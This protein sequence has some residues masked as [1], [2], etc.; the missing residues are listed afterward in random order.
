MSNFF[1]KIN[2]WSLASLNILWILVLLLFATLGSPDP[3][4]VGVLNNLIFGFFIISLIEIFFIHKF[5]FHKKLIHTYG[6]FLILIVM[7]I[8]LVLVMPPEKDL[9][10]LGIYVVITPLVISLISKFVGHFTE[11]QKNEKH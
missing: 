4:G 2:F 10:R 3:F 9:Y 11:R 8:Y 7:M 6:S 1:T 5:D